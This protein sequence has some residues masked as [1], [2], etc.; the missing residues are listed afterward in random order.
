MR[1]FTLS[2]LTASATAKTKGID[3]TPTAQHKANLEALVNNVLDPLRTAYG[4][5]IRVTSGYRSYD[6]NKTVGGSKTS[7]HALGMASDITGGSVFE[8]IKLFQL[9][10]D[11]D[12]PFDQ[13]I[14][15][16]GNNI[17]PQWIHISYDPTR[18]RKQ[19]LRTI[20]GK[21]YYPCDRNGKA[22]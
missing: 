11:L 10:I 19:I 16:K 4:K 13:L 5:P 14:F 3:N 2:E 21:T 9:V 8:N 20:N 22:I 12:L 1:F 15:E 7:Q 17:G 6:L 18:N